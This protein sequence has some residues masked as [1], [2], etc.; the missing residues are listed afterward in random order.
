[1]K[2]QIKSRVKELLDAYRAANNE[3]NAKIKQWEQDQIYAADYRVEKIKAI[4]QDAEKTDKLFN[5]KLQEVIQSERKAIIG[6]PAAKPADYQMQIANA[7]EFIKLAGDKLNDDQLAGI[8]KPFQADFETMQ[9]FK[10]AVG[11]LTTGKGVWGSFE[12][13]FAKTNNFTVL[14]NNFNLAEQAAAN[15]FDS[16]DNSLEGAVKTGMFLDAV[17]TIERLANTVAA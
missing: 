4:K 14:V 6:E 1:M 5:G 17:D 13:T 9:L 15:L 10:A 2:T 8:L 16:Q 3:F 7:L 12:K 11:G